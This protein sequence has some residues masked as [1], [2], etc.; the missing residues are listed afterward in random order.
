MSSIVHVAL[1]RVYRSSSSYGDSPFTA[2]AGS[3]KLIPNGGEVLEVHLGQVPE[4]LQ[5]AEARATTIFAAMANGVF[6]NDPSHR[7]QLNERLSEAKDGRLV[8]D[9]HKWLV[10][11]V[12]RWQSDWSDEVITEEPWFW[13]DSVKMCD[14]QKIAKERIP[15]LDLAARVSRHF[16]PNVFDEVVVS[17]RMYVARD[18]SFRDAFPWPH[19]SAGH[20]TIAVRSNIDS[21]EAALAG[22][23]ME[24]ALANALAAPAV[25]KDQARPHRLE[26]ALHSDLLADDG[27]SYGLYELLRELQSVLMRASYARPISVMFIDMNGL[28]QINDTLGHGAGDEAIAEFRRAVRKAHHGALFRTGGDE[29]VL[30]FIGAPDAAAT[31]ARGILTAVAGCQVKGAALS[32]S[33]GVV[34]A[35][36]PLESPKGIVERA[37]R[38]MYRAKEASRRGLPRPCMLA[39]DGAE[40]EEVKSNGD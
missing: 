21:V 36:D 14:M 34:L 2:P 5:R 17:D 38:E 10:A 29:F 28:K 3:P 35:S 32:A 1:A 39:F 7:S 23:E 20:A 26:A 4:W 9:Q 22:C 33:V 18:E 31:F 8:E 11:F 24:R 30:F 16:V 12:L 15:S 6:R 37:D 13:I 19:F 40:V 25:P 27:G